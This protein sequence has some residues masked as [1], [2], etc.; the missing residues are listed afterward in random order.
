[1][2]KDNAIYLTEIYY[3]GNVEN[4]VEFRIRPIN[5]TSLEHVIDGKRVETHIPIKGTYYS[6]EHL[7]C[8]HLGNTWTS[9]NGYYSSIEKAK[10]K[11]KEDKSLKLIPIFERKHKIQKLLKDLF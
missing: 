1:M 8:R 11:I 7:Q 2:K 10:E 3:I 4:T 6:I 9:E 5:F